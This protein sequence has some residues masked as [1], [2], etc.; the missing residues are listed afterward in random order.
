[1]KPFSQSCENNRQPILEVLLKCFALQNRI[2]E[3]GSGTGQHAVYF[4][5]FLTD[6]IW[7]TSDRQQNH[8]GI[9]QWI[10]GLSVGNLER[11][12]ELDVEKAENW[13]N[14]AALQ[15]MNPVNGAFTANTV[16]IMP[17]DS[18]EKMFSG[19]GRL[20]SI[21]DNNGVSTRGRF[22]V[23]GPFNRDSEFT[24]SGNAAF[25]QQLRESD[26]LMGIRNDRD[27]F[28]LADRS[29]LELTDDIDMPANNRVLVFDYS[30]SRKFKALL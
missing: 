28:E 8:K 22:V 25:H 12:L 7:Q 18:V 10:D 1:M 17:W 11:P 30:K 9:N 26:P 23:Y 15:R 14:L 3:I 16:H 29:A 20:F 27:V 5:E 21:A 13:D 4:S 6:L 24:S 2:L 19:V